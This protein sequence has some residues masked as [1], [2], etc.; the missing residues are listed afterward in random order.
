MDSDTT[1]QVLDIL[2]AAQQRIEAGGECPDMEFIIQCRLLG[3]SPIDIIT[4]GEVDRYITQNGR[5][6]FW[7]FSS[8]KL[9]K[10]EDVGELTK[11]ENEPE[12]ELVNNNAIIASTDSECYLQPSQ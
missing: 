10:P 9:L 2:T 8:S 11:A 6:T 3:Y 1:H 7:K 4:L 5:P 12:I